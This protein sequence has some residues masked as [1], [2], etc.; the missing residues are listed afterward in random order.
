MFRPDRNVRGEDP[1]LLVKLAIFGVAATIAVIGIALQYQWV[2]FAAIIV[3]A[4]GF[5]IGLIGR[6][7]RERALDEAAADQEDPDATT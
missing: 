3:L 7:L 4:V 2:I 1:L 6:R 5:V